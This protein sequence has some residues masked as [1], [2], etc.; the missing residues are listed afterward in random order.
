MVDFSQYTDLDLV[1]KTLDGEAG[2]QG[3]A[4]IQGVGSVILRRA[5]L[6]WQ[7]E[8][9]V[10]GVCTHPKQFDCWGAGPDLDRITDVNYSPPSDCITIAKQVLDGSLPDNTGGA[11]SYIVTGT[12][13]YWAENL[14]PTAVIGNQSFYIT[15][16][17]LPPEAI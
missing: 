12:P 13:C 4:G 7:G 2:D 3:Y 15:R 10:R 14:T 9:T 11:D 17:T 6:G 8:K 16:H 5:Q 1:I